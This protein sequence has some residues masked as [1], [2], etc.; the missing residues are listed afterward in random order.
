MQIKSL[1]FFLSALVIALTGIRAV[2]AQDRGAPSVD[3]TPPYNPPITGNEFT[4][5][6]G[7]GDVQVTLSWNNLDDM[8]LWIYEPNGEVIYYGRRTSSTG[9]QLDQDA[10]AACNRTPTSVE[11]I[12][13]PEGQAPQGTYTA[14]VKLWASCEPSVAQWT[15]R[16]TVN[17]Q[18]VLNESG[19]ASFAQYTFENNPQLGCVDISR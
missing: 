14:Q 10:Q 7:A 9:G 17:G 15:L 18:I 5:Q 6:I 11:N 2:T 13:W 1:V 4:A 8:D 12:F 16:A 19:N 3:K